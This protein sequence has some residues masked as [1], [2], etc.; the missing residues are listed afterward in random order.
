M[1]KGSLSDT[2]LFTMERCDGEV[3]T[4]Q[5]EV[6]IFPNDDLAV[7]YIFDWQKVLNVHGVGKYNIKVAFTIAGIPGGFT[8][9]SYELKNFSRENVKQSVRVYSEFNSYYQK[10]NIDFTDSNFKDCIRFNGFF[11]KREPETQINNLISKG[12]EVLKV[13]RENL[14]RYTLLTDPIDI[15]M[16]KQL[17]DK[18][19][20]NE[21]IIKISDY[22]RFNHD[23]NIFDKSLALIDTPKAEYIDLDRR[24][25][26]TASF[27]DKKLEDKTYYR[28]T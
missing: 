22:N 11:G 4:N 5:G 9:G 3:V 19:L 6:A 16:S 18:H 26:I 24:V 17:L 25:K 12:R 15:C 20:L 21:N 8:T 28:T 13:T 10:D 27:G 14:N 7:G 1:K 23:F 2:I